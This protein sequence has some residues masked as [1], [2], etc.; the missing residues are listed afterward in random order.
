[1]GSNETCEVEDYI[2]GE[3][4]LP[5]CAGLDDSDWESSFFAELNQEQDPNEE[6]EEDEEIEHSQMI[7]TYKYANVYLEELHI[8]FE[9]EGHIEEA[10]KID[11]IMDKVSLLSSKKQTTSDSW[12]IH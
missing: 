3:N 11:S 9:K 5:V 1:M 6:H 12:L 10:L 7:K 2:T 8:F 4:S